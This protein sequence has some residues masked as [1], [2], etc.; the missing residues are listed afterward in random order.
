MFG[1]W[2]THYDYVGMRRNSIWFLAPFPLACLPQLI[3]WVGYTI[4]MGSLTGSIVTAVFTRKTA[5]E[6]IL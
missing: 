5:W 6:E 2:G 3:F 1:N 4:L